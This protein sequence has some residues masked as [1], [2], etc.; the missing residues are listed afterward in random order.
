MASIGTGV[1]YEADVFFNHF[2]KKRVLLSQQ[3]TLNVFAAVGDWHVWLQT[4][5]ATAVSIFHKKMEQAGLEPATLAHNWQ[6]TA[7]CASVPVVI[8]APPRA[9][10]SHPSI[11]NPRLQTE[12]G[13][14]ILR[15]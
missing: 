10:L 1:F 7:F 12:P 15:L 8:Y 11:P 14:H 3:D 13:A 2:V 4:Y 6:R 5:K 9:H